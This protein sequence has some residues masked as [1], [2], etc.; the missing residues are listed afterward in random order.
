M[1]L[2]TSVDIKLNG[3]IALVAVALV[4]PVLVKKAWT[5]FKKVVSRG[6]LLRVDNVVYKVKIVRGRSLKLAL[7]G[8][9]I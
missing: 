1:T 7:D 4:E 5:P 3:H 9:P 8:T 6:D 2:G